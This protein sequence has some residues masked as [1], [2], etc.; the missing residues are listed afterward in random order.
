V[1]K[2]IDSL[3]TELGIQNIRYCHW[4]SNNNLDAALAGETDVDLLV[5]SSRK[6]DFEAVLRALR[7]QKSVE[8][9]WKVPPF[10]FH[11]YGLD[12]A[13]GV[14]VHLHIYFEIITGGSVFKNHRLKLEEMYF[15]NCRSQNGVRVPCKEVELIVLVLRKY[16]EHTSII[17][18]YLLSK[19]HENIRRE[20]SWLLEGID[21]P[22]AFELLRTWL[23]GF[24]VDRFFDQVEAL[25]NGERLLYRLKVGFMVRRLLAGRTLH[26]GPKALI[27][28]S[29]I[30]G[31]D[32]IEHKLCPN[33]NDRIISPCGGVIAFVGPEASGKST[34]VREIGHWLGKD[35]R[36]MSVHCGKPPATAVS[37]FLKM[38][39]RSYVFF[40]R[41]HRSHAGDKRKMGG[42]IGPGRDGNTPHPIVS[43]IDAY[44]RLS[45]TR[46]VRRQAS[47]GAIVLTDR[48]PSKQ[49]G[50]I[51]GPRI[52]PNGRVSSLLSRMEQELYRRVPLPTAVIKVAAP[53]SVTMERNSRRQMPEPESFLRD[54]Y[55]R[56]QQ[57][58]FPDVSCYTVD[59]NG[60]FDESLLNVKRVVWTELMASRPPRFLNVPAI[61]RTAV[62]SGARD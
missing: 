7:F 48:Y 23:P 39:I 5:D 20:I 11:Y 61:R 42:E 50:G 62:T 53:L 2:L 47:K 45:L 27:L 54:R 35:F 40:K 52:R 28:R 8:P 29:L 3:M 43:L 1:L 4:K 44:D 25:Q 41:F 15:Q 59:N 51:D 32:L 46:K 17:E 55:E 36:L 58:Q 6:R 13:T 22:R 24:D 56:F 31:W 38:G 16:L 30:F 37:Y 34:F 26:W 14:L 12:D 10:V 57:L 49:L 18:F 19:D 21:R 60:S 9:G 33:R